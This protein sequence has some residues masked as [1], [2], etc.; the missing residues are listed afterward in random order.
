MT[1]LFSCKKKEIEPKQEECP[2]V[3]TPI[4]Q[5]GTLNFKTL[6]NCNNVKSFTAG[7]LYLFKTLK[8]RDNNSVPVYK[9]KSSPND[10]IIT[11]QS[12]NEEYYYTLY[13]RTCTNDLI[14]KV[15]TIK[16]RT[17]STSKLH[18]II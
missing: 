6:K 16:I 4:V 14:T 5:Y 11:I 13:G 17:D 7:D 1:A 3:T 12:Q 8:D 18:I 2:V 9:V 15:G 10:S